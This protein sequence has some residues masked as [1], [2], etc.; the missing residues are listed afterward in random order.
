[1]KCIINAKLQWLD[2]V[3]RKVLPY[4]YHC[5]KEENSWV[6]KHVPIEELEPK[7]SS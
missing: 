3:D 7:K 6:T 2:L 1:M 4:M 5:D